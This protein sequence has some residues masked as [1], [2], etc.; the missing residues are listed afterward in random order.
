MGVLRRPCA[1]GVESMWA[2]R[3]VCQLLWRTRAHSAATT[4][5]TWSQA[6]SWL[7]VTSEDHSAT[8]WTVAPNMASAPN[9]ALPTLVARL[10]EHDDVVMCAAV[11]PRARLVATGSNDGSM[12]TSGCCGLCPARAAATCAANAACLFVFSRLFCSRSR[13]LV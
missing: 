1:G 4:S 2:A 7:V 9:V 8:V 11:E 6:A 3:A 12:W 13:G 10:D 5:V